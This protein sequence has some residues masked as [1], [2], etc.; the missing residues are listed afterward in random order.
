MTKRFTTLAAFVAA[1]AILAPA[2]AFA[3]TFTGHVTGFSPTSISV[4]DREIITV[5][6]DNSTAFTKLITQ[7]P[8]Q[9]DA[10]L[11][12]SALRVG[13]YVAVHVPDGGTVATWVQIA[14]DFRAEAFAAVVQ[15]PV[16]P[17]NDRVE[18]ARHRSEARARRMSPTASE[19]K[20]PGG[21]D[22]AIHCDRIA[23]RLEH[24]GK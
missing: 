13:R 4:F 6:L 9:Q 8:W 19:S 11:T 24:L 12:A 5:G 17:V 21:P 22:T 20:R 2:T 14:T 3:K 10:A 15:T 16:A 1:L 7:K 18:A 23:D